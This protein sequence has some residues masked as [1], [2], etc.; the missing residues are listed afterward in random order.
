MTHTRARVG[1]DVP[2]SQ[3]LGTNPKLVEPCLHLGHARTLMLGSLIAEEMEIPFDVRLD[4]KKDPTDSRSHDVGVLFSL[5]SIIPKL[6]VDCRRVYWVSQSRATIAEYERQFGKERGSR[7]HRCIWTIAESRID[8]VS[9]IEDDLIFHH[10][11]LAIRGSEFSEIQ[12]SENDTI[13]RYMEHLNDAYTLA[14]REMSQTTVQLITMEYNKI[15]KSIGTSLSWEIFRRFPGEWIRDFLI[16]TSI[17]PTD[18]LAAIGEPF[19]INKMA[20]SP[21]EWS[22]DIWDQYI[23]NRKRE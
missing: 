14:D 4:G 2:S 13:K 6:G 8:L 20:D 1:I 10:P 5:C 17:S 21:Y 12:D 22:W 15:S 19:V 3:V 16:A 18:P 23:E 11:S 7:L 9:M